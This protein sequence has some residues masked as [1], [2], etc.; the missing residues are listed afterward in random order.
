MS[1]L[2]S[3]AACDFSRRFRRRKRVGLSL[4]ARGREMVVLSDSYVELTLDKL[5]SAK[6]AL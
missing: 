4:H 6:E 1:T 2:F 5:V 3:G